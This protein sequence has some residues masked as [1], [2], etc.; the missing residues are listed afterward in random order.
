MFQ[1]V[2][3]ERTGPDATM[4]GL[5]CELSNYNAEPQ[6]ERNRFHEKGTI[7]GV[8]CPCGDGSGSPRNL[9]GKTKY[10]EAISRSRR[11]LA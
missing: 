3:M 5:H 10:S 6:A 8:G 1:L 9:P 2:N 7:F 4:R 11:I